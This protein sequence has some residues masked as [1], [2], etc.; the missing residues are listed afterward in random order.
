VSDYDIAYVLP[1]FRCLDY[2]RRALLSLFKYTPKAVAIIVDDATPPREWNTRWLANIGGQT[3]VF[4]YEK[5]GGLTRSWNQGLLLAR[6]YGVKFTVIGNNDVLFTEG[7]WQPMTR[8]LDEG[9]YG[10]V[11]PVSNAPGRT[12]GKLQ[13]IEHYVPDYSLT[14]NPTYNNRIAKTL[15]AKHGDEAVPVDAVNGFFMA[16]KTD[17]WF[18]NAFDKNHVFCPVNRR[19]PSGK[20]NPTPLM[21][22]NE[23]ELQ[24]RWRKRGIRSAVVPAS[25][26]FHY[27]SVAR[28]QR[29]IIGNA[30]RLSDAS[31]EV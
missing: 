14:D 15:H 26:I 27:R 22:V 18:N 29:Y 10:L 19:A 2:A 25:F 21:T 9:T 24:T 16:A 5:N 7:W 8:V 4:R 11:G 3:R 20:L 13:L 12:A 31:K 23:D 28:G 30:F 17:T 6:E 1:S